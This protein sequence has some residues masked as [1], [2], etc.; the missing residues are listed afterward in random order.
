M[1][2]LKTYIYTILI[3]LGVMVMPTLAEGVSLPS[4]GNHLEIFAAQSPLSPREILLLAGFSVII[5]L[6][7][8]AFFL[9]QKLSKRTLLAFLMINIL[10]SIFAILMLINSAF[11][12]Q[13]VYGVL[14]VILMIILFKLMNQ[15]EI[16]K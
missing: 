7:L 16:H 8:T 9:A 3:A 4:D 11:S 2:F 14:S 10:I 15:F 1:G 13:P 5:V 6:G 12:D